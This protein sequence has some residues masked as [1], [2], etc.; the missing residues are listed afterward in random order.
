MQYSFC[1]GIPFLSVYYDKS[2]SLVFLMITPH[3]IGLPFH[4]S[5]SSL[6]ER[7]MPLIIILNFAKTKKLVLPIFWLNHSF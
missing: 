6:L 7:P 4:C 1:R 5:I 2:R 3:P